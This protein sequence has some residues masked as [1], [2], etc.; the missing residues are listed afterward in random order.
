MNKPEWKKE[1]I[2]ETED[3]TSAITAAISALDIANKHRTIHVSTKS[4][5]DTDGE[6]GDVWL[7]IEK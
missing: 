7:T 4:P 6:N 1:L 5:S 3:R 2:K